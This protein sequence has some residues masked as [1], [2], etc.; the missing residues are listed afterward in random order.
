MK[1]SR[2]VNIPKEA[3]ASALQ[4]GVT[5][6]ELA[7]RYECSPTTISKRV[8]EY[9]LHKDSNGSSVSKEQGEEE[10][11]EDK[12]QYGVG[13]DIGT[14]NLVSAR[15]VM[16]SVETKRVRDAFLDVDSA[17]KKMLNLRGTS[18]VEYEDQ[19]LILGDTALELAQLLKREVRRPLS[20]GLISSS[21]IDALEVLSILIEQVVGEPLFEGEICYYSIPAAP[22]D[23]PGQDI[24]Y[25]EAVFAKVLE[26]L[27]YDPVSGNEAMAII[28]SECAAEGFSGIACSFGA[29][30]ANVALSYMT[31]PILEFSVQRSGDFID[32]NAAKAVG[33]TA[34]RMCA[35]KERGIDLMN[36]TSREEEALAVYY[37]SVIKYALDNISKKFKQTQ[38]DTELQ[39]AIPIVVSG[40]TS[41]A[42]GFLDLFKEVFEKQRKRFPIEIS[43][44]R[45]AEDPMTSVAQG[46][47]VQ[48]LAESE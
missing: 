5:Y 38:S 3:L 12:I 26:E 11:S 21:E 9:G 23:N 2:R 32:E 42:G 15:K 14:G 10:M 41:L 18:Y 44:I 22:L 37:K 47:L 6:V 29:G 33:T 17:R 45:Q 48:A 39:E 43:E 4:D 46:L 16:D 7:E 20:K 27:G 13:L 25:H 1:V 40:G 28:Y 36:P 8:K 35:I 19:L 31:M 30:M 24:V 34:S